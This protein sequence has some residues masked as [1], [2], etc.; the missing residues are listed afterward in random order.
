MYMEQLVKYG[1]ASKITKGL[2]IIADTVLS[3]KPVIDFT[4]QNI[5]QAAPVALPWAGVCVWLQVSIPYLL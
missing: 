4:I 2:G 3:A 5:P 1:Q